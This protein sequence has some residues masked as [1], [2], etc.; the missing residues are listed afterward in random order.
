M[1][2]PGLATH[3]WPQSQFHYKVRVRPTTPPATA[4]GARPHIGIKPRTTQPPQCLWGSAG[5]LKDITFPTPLIL[6]I[7]N[8]LFG[9]PVTFGTQVVSGSPPSLPVQTIIGTLQPGE[10]VSIPLQGYSAVFATCAV[11]STVYCFIKG[12]A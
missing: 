12:S 8:D 2:G 4:A 1:Y 5:L 3:E 7:R 6:H 11:E 10:C 9:E